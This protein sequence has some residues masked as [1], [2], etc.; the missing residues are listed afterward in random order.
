MIS[1]QDKEMKL[2]N[3]IPR[4][5]SEKTGQTPATKQSGEEGHIE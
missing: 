3:E 1:L 4:L 5:E 2:T